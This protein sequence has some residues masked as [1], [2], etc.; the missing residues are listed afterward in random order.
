MRWPCSLTVVE[1]STLSKILAYIQFRRLPW[2]FPWCLQTLKLIP[3]A[4]VESLHPPRLTIHQ[5]LVCWSQCHACNHVLAMFTVC[6]RV[7][8]LYSLYKH[9]S[10]SHTKLY[11]MSHKCRCDRS[12]IYLKCCTCCSHPLVSH[13]ER[14]LSC[15][16]KVSY[17][18][19]VLRVCLQGYAYT[20]SLAHTLSHFFK[21]LSRK[22][23][24]NSRTSTELQCV[25]SALN[26]HVLLPKIANNL[27]LPP[28]HSALHNPRIN[29]TNYYPE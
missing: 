24:S 1:A 10:H 21:D 15:W 12:T 28:R 3:W 25:V 20:S 23:P 11:A 26:D 27:G 29:P 17:R 4:Y 13:T 18:R 19:V 16:F 8:T 7:Y 5:T 14:M 2:F 9:M 6:L 22:L